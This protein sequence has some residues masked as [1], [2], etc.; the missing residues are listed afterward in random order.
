VPTS[1]AGWLCAFFAAAGDVPCNNP[2]FSSQPHLQQLSCGT[3]A[4]GLMLVLGVVESV[5]CQGSTGV[6]ASYSWQLWM[7]L[8]GGGGEKMC[9]GT[10]LQPL[11]ALPLSPRSI[12]HHTHAQ[13]ALVMDS[14]CTT[15]RW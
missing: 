7:M 3:K 9:G 2:A 12:H 5:L 11:I 15:P 4:L 13:D 1:C 8:M 14:G 10:P 6:H